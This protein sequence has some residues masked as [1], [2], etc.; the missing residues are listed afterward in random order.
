MKNSLFEHLPEFDNHKLV[1]FF[2]DKA[3]KLRGFIAVHN[4]KQNIAVGGTRYWKYSSESEAL[5]D[6]LNLSRAMTYKCA[7][8]GVPYGGGKGVIMAGSLSS[9]KQQALVAYAQRINMLNGTFYTGEDVGI[10]QGDVATLSKQSKFI[11]GRPG[12]AGDP[13]PWAALGVFYAIQAG[14]QFLFKNSEVQNRT[15]AIKGIGKVGGEL[16]RLIYENNGKVIAADVDKER[17]KEI[18]E[19][20]PNIHIV[21]A[22]E[23]HKQKVDVYCP[24]A[25]GN[26]F[27]KTTI[28]QLQ[29]KMICGG[30]NNQLSSSEAG[31]LLHKKNILYIPDYLANAGGL[32]NVVA[33]LDSNGYKKKQVETKVKDIGKTATKIFELSEKNKKSTSQMADE[34][35]MQI[36]SK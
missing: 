19:Q 9:A 15:F 28:S 7:L 26:E 8:A 18:K 30:A 17:L 31:E 10:D 35:A 3:S 21:S 32:I 36:F 29:C 1:S 5:V 24:C 27:T 34:L 2:Y 22:V 23:I 13:S 20:F 4:I 33:E 16:L 6:A 12:I 25:L 11:I 14:L